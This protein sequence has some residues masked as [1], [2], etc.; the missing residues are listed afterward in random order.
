MAARRLRRAASY[1]ESFDP[2]MN[3]WLWRDPAA[4]DYKQCMPPS[5][6]A[7]GLCVEWM[8]AKAQHLRAEMVRSGAAGWRVSGGCT[9][10]CSH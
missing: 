8:Q 7:D 4:G 1:A 10:R 2:R 9:C 6:L 5:E 3:A